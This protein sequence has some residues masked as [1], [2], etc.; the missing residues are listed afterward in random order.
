MGC[1]SRP[2]SAFGQRIKYFTDQNV[3][4]WGIT[5]KWILGILKFR[6]ECYK[7]LE[8]KIEMK[9]GIICLVSMFPSWVMCLKLSEIEHFFSN[10]ELT[11]EFSVKN[12]SL[13]K[14]FTYTH[15]EGLVMHF[16]KMV[17]SIMLWLIVSVI[18]GRRIIF[19]TFLLNQ[20]LFW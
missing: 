4:K 11:L 2:K 5:W 20:H 15:R 3:P 18:L 17:L 9:N 8:R 12:L 14:E 6:N 7:G 13:L 1:P 10:F 16:Y 19:I